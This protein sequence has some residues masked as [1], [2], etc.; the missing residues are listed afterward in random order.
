MN[1]CFLRRKQQEPRDDNETHTSGLIHKTSSTEDVAA[2][3]N[4]HCS[5]D[6]QQKHTK[7]FLLDSMELT[8]IRY[9]ANIL[10]AVFTC[11]CEGRT[12]FQHKNSPQ[13]LTVTHNWSEP[14][15]IKRRKENL[16]L[17]RHTVKG[18]RLLAS[19]LLIQ[20]KH[21]WMEKRSQTETKE[22]TLDFQKSLPES[23][24]NFHWN[25]FLKWN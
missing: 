18:F 1:P 11:F 14:A 16:K 4:T 15:S 24:K 22:S 7:C 12:L 2:S 8:G 21:N 23:E 5:P 17:S 20:L 9:E 3:N 19:F 13:H 25:F 10:D 6:A